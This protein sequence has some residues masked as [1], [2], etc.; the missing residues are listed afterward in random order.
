LRS[1][2]PADDDA[3]FDEGLAAAGAGDA[4]AARLFSARSRIVGGHAQPASTSSYLSG[5]LIGAEVAGVPLLLGVAGAA[6]TL[7]GDAALCARYR[8]ALSQAGVEAEVFDG[9][10][11]AIAGLWALAAT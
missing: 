8:R 9:E 10:V 3:A 5:L 7:L 2:A 1:D 11:A 4:L 6:V